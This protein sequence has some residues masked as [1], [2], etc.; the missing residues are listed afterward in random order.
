ML[1]FTCGIGVTNTGHCHPR[2]VEAA[3]AQCARLVHGQVNIGFH[4]P[5]LELI[6]ELVPLMP[7]D[8]LDSFFFTTTGAEAVENAV[9]LAKN[10]TGRSN[11][12]V[13]QGGYHGRTHLTMA[14]TTSSLIYRQDFGPFPPGVVVAPFPYELHGHSVSHCLEAMEQL[15]KQQV[16]PSEVAAMVIEPVLGEGGYVP[17]P[18][19]FAVGLRQICDAHGI[20]LVADEVQT[21]FGRTGRLF[22][23]EYFVDHGVVP[24]IMVM[25]KGLASGFPLAAIASRR[26]LMDKQPP[27]SM[28]GTYAGNAVSCAAAIATQRVIQDEKLV[29]NAATQGTRLMGRLGDVAQKRGQAVRDVRGLGCMVGLEL[30]AAQPLGTAKKVTQACAEHGILLLPCSIFETVRFIPPLNVTATEIDEAVGIFEK[31]LDQVVPT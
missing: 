19:E 3:Q 10:A 6:E 30:A 13:F 27:G 29:A 21:G 16:A 26:E 4:E 20:L 18:P 8:S 22:A 9:K 2:V 31:A 7:H 23:S 1:D 11:I 14:M 28:G 17:A 25:A 24:D 12:I 5:M 15:L